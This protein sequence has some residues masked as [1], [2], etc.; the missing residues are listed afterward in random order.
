MPIE[1]WLLTAYYNNGRSGSEINQI[2]NKY[3]EYDKRKS[4]IRSI[5]FAKLRSLGPIGIINTWKTK[6]SVLFGIKSDFGMM[7]SGKYL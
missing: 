7:K 3:Q 2:T 4:Y 1:S 5:L 6:C